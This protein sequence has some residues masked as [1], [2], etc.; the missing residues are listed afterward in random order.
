MKQ[1]DAV[2]AKIR[3][4][5]Y[6]H[7]IPDEFI[8]LLREDFEQVYAMGF[9]EGKKYNFKNTKRLHTSVIRTDIHNN[10]KVFRSVAEAARKSYCTTDTIFTAL[11]NGRMHKG[12]F[13]HKVNEEMPEVQV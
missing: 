9:D 4:I 3:D 8:G 7:K 5:K 13:W 6:Q 1:E 11:K 10:K 12:Y 2:Q